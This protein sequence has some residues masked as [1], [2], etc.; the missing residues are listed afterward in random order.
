[1]LSKENEEFFYNFIKEEL[2]FHPSSYRNCPW[3]P[4]SMN[5]PFAVY[6]ISDVSDEQVDLLYELAPT[7]LANCLQP[8]HQ[9]YWFDWQHSLVLYDPRNP[10]N[11]QSE[12]EETPSFN[13]K[14]IAYFGGFFPDGDYYFYI[15]KYGAFG[16]LSHPW[17][18]EVWI[19]GE[20]LLK[21]FDAIHKQIGFVKK[22]M[23]K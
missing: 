12:K 5:R 22:A 14:G 11:Y 17:R 8:G 20:K 9:L 4:F 13:S 15:D 2:R 3:L 1:M 23:V 21:E 19:F 10:E 7:A 6:D 16:Y 18:Q